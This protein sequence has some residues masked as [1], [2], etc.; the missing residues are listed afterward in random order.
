VTRQVRLRRSIKPGRKKV[1]ATDHLYQDGLFQP[2][3]VEFTKLPRK[4]ITLW[5]IEIATSAVILTAIVATS[6]AC[7]CPGGSAGI[8][9][10]P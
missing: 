6:S 4:V 7:S 1:L 10:G 5:R 8:H 3:D 9:S 2:D